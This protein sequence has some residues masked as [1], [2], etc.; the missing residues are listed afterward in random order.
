MTARS[1]LL[2]AAALASLAAAPLAALA[3]AAPEYQPPSPADDRYVAPRIS[4]EYLAALARLP[5]WNG[6]W[7]G[8]RFKG[9]RAFCATCADFHLEPDP[10]P[11]DSAGRNPSFPAGSKDLGIPYNA[12]Y[13]KVYD[14]RIAKARRGADIDP[15]NCLTPHP[16]PDAM[17]TAFDVSGGMEI[18]VRPGEVRLV[19]DWLNATRR[20]YTDGR[21]H[22]SVDDLWPTHMGHSIGK[23]EGDTL[24]VD[25]VAM[26]PGSYDMTGAPYSDK[27]HMVERLRMIGKDKLENVMTV[28]DPVML[29]KP[30]TVR[31]TYSRTPLPKNAIIGS[32]CSDVRDSNSSVPASLIQ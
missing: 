7:M 24:V 15:D 3:Q 27:V 22:P 26:F 11:A 28:E 23:W 25:T 14:Y 4:A 17:T 13:M 31:R 18:Q 5:D 8:D 10:A 19:W 20:I 16:T 6:Q 30:F 32:Y 21:P 9:L 12:Q 2:A 29:T 1:T